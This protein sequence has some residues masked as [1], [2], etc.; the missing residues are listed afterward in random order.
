[1]LLAF[2]SRNSNWWL[3]VN[4]T[5]MHKLPWNLNK[6]PNILFNKMLFNIFPAKYYPISIHVQHRTVYKILPVPGSHILLSP[7]VSGPFISCRCLP[8]VT[9]LVNWFYFQSPSPY[10]DRLHLPHSSFKQD[11][12]A[13]RHMA[14]PNS[15]KG[16]EKGMLSLEDTTT[17]NTN[18]LLAQ[19]S[20]S[21]CAQPMRDDVTE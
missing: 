17:R 11:F 9:Y 1:M 12:N 15:V 4:W 5:I 18:A 14:L 3:L 13:S 20:F 6:T 7:S 10:K 16:S 21:G 2:Y 19:G 8:A